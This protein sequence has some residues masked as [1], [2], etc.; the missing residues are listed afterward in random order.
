MRRAGQD[1]LRAGE[2]MMLVTRCKPHTLLFHLHAAR[3]L[4]LLLPALDCQLQLKYMILYDAF[5][6]EFGA[7]LGDDFAK[8]L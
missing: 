8:F 3:H 6:Q 1:R 5:T 2:S 4:E 7:R